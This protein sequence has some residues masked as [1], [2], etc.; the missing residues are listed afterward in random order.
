MEYADV[1]AAYQAMPDDTYKIFDKPSEGR[2]LIST[3]L[4]KAMATGAVQGATL[5]VVKV[6]SD[7]PGMEAAAQAFFARTGRTCTI[8]SRDEVIQPNWELRYTCG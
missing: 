7:L 3:S 8:T 5:G 2:M 4:G 1:T 6:P